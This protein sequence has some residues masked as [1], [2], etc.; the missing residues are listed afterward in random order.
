M[1]NLSGSGHWKQNNHSRGESERSKYSYF[2]SSS[3]KS[4]NLDDE[5]SEEQFLSGGK[6][7][8]SGSIDSEEDDLAFM[9]AQE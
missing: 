6:S 5:S 7:S 1:R 2:M 8:K 9:K 3:N 4:K